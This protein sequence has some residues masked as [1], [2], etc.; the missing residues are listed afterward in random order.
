MAKKEPKIAEKV[1]M[2]G[3]LTKFL[4]YPERTGRDIYTN[5]TLGK[6]F[7]REEDEIIEVIR[8]KES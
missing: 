8:D 5:S 1:R 6:M 2:V 3:N 4:N 7:E